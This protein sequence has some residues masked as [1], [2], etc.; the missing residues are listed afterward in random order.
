[1]RLL[2]DLINEKSPVSTMRVLSLV[3]MLIGGAVAMFGVYRG[4]DMLGVA[5]VA[6]VFVSA[7]I[8]GKVVQK[9]IEVK[10]DK[11][12]DQNYAPDQPHKRFIPHA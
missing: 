1:M 8:T 9:S 11:S 6:G 5:A 10:S 3:A 12:S 4:S 7:S 2:R